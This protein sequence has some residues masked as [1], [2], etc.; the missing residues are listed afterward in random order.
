MP[1]YRVILAYDGTK[2]H[3]FQSQ[4]QLRTVQGTIE[5]GLIKMTKGIPVTVFGAGRT[6]AGV[7]AQGQ[8]VHFDFP[9]NIPPRNMLLG[10]NSI[11]P[12]DI[13]IK[14]VAIVPDTFH[15]QFSTVGKR[16]GYRVSRTRFTDPFKRFYTGHYPYALELDRIRTALAD[17]IGTHDY[18]S[19]A[20]SGGVIKNKVRTIY[21]ATMTDHPDDDELY[22]EFIGNGFLYN[23][24]RI[25]VGVLLEIGNNRRPVTEFPRLYAVKDRQEARITAP[26]SG[27][28]LQEVYYD[29]AALAQAVAERQE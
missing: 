23:M 2:F 27:L 5:Q 18:T 9:G 7:H 4:P 3:G 14:D 6:D 25:L 11:M 13:V 10:L 26:A 29:E 16:Y 17:V 21:T 20:A 1:R 24:V 28:Y 19:F 12:L 8:V 22:F 15:A